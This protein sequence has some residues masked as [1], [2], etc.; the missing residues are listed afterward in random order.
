ML[1]QKLKDYSNSGIYPFHMPGHKR[2]KTD[3]LPLTIDITEIGG[4]DNLHHPVGCLDDLQKTAAELFGARHAFALVNGSTV[5]VLSAVRAMTKAGDR[6]LFSRNCHLS[7]YHAA[8]LCGLDVAYIV[9]DAVNE[10]G[11][12]ASVS[13]EAVEQQLIADPAISLVVVTSP[14]YEGV[15]SDIARIAEICH[16]YGARLFVDEAHGAHFPFSDSFPKNAVQC[17]ADAAVTSLHKTLPA[18]TQT[19]LLLLS[20]E[21]LTKEVQRQLSVFETSSPS[22]VL[23]A[24]VDR[25]LEFL[26]NSERAFDA[27]IDRLTRFYDRS[28]SLRHLSV[29]YDVFST[30]ER[31]FD[32]DIGKLCIFC[33]GFMTGKELMERLR[34]EYRIELEAALGDYAL[35]MT[36]VCD[37][38]EGFDRLLRA[39]TEIDSQCKEAEHPIGFAV[40]SLPPKRYSIAEALRKDGKMHDIHNAEGRISREYI[41]VYPPGVPLIVPGEEITRGVLSQLNRLEASSNEILTDSSSFPLIS[42]IS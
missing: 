24:S 21:A 13:P 22:Y 34:S 32:F 30:S 28:R 19:A 1:Y 42:I 4:F 36:S 15:V 17:G 40:T 35:A 27:Y 16:R 23:L 39:L 3:G 20:D 10:S 5:G 38:D 14:T 33:R 12:F 31:V 7:V 11:I 2:I 8:E 25:C 18:M 37:T 26:K 29:S 9:P 6:V 41:R